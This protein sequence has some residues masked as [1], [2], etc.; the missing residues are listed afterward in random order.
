MPLGHGARN[1]HPLAL[2]AGKVR[3]PFLG[4]LC[5][6]DLLQRLQRHFFALRI[7]NLRIEQKWHGR[8]FQGV[9]VFHQPEILKNESDR[10]VADARFFPLG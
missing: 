4:Q 8:V 7:G 3:N 1:C 10:L 2:A 6:P 9:A 5:K